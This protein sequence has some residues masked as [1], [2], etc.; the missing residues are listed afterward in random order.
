MSNYLNVVVVGLRDTGKST[1]CGGLLMATNGTAERNLMKLYKLASEMGRPSYTLAWLM[2]VRKLER[3]R[4]MTVDGNIRKLILPNGRCVNLMDAPGAKSFRRRAISM[5]QQADVVLVC[6]DDDDKF[7]PQEFKELLTTLFFFRIRTLAFCAKK[8]TSPLMIESVRRI[9]KTVGFPVNNIPLF[10]IGLVNNPAALG[11][12]LED[13][14]AREVLQFLMDAPTPVRDVKG[15]LLMLVNRAYKIGGVGTVVCGGIVRGRIRVGENVMI[16]PG[17]AVVP[18]TSLQVWHDNV[19]EAYAG[20][21]VGVVIKNYNVHEFQRGG[22]HGFLLGQSGNSVSPHPMQ[23]APVMPV[24]TLR[25]ND[26][27]MPPKCGNFT[28]PPY[29]NSIIV[30]VIVVRDVLGLRAK[31]LTSGASV[32]V[33]GRLS[34]Q[35]F[36]VEAVLARL[37]NAFETVEYRPETVER[38]S[39]YRLQLRSKEGL[40]VDTKEKNEP[41][42]RVILSD[43]V[44]VVAAGVVRSTAAV[45]VRRI[46]IDPKCVFA[47]PSWLSAIRKVFNVEVIPLVIADDGSLDATPN[48]SCVLC[49][50]HVPNFSK[51]LAVAS[52]ISILVSCAQPDSTSIYGLT[53][54]PVK[55][56]ASRHNSYCAVTDRKIN[57]D[58]AIKN[59]RRVWNRKFQVKKQW[60]VP[61]KYRPTP[62]HTALGRVIA[63]T[64]AE[65]REGDAEIMKAAL[66][67]VTTTTRTT[68]TSPAVAIT[69]SSRTEAT[70]LQTRKVVLPVDIVELIVDY[71]ATNVRAVLCVS[72]VS[73]AW[74][75]ATDRDAFFIPFLVAHNVPPPPPNAENEPTTADDGQL[76]L[77][78]R[79]YR[80]AIQA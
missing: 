78:T 14:S 72:R 13:S 77:R 31:P 64:R 42:S 56:A 40:V 30:D 46:A 55:L 28:L 70:S 45:A 22:W 43:S 29:T 6:V 61:L 25:A 68:P 63:A 66:T 49:G 79:P 35:H 5:A 48:V 53:V 51:F 76:Q 65:Q 16:A 18:I 27:V 37:D 1:L 7:C 52:N 32:L 57:E 11:L 41:F 75:V 69:T 10:R 2:D 4:C 38:K 60:F 47:D 20:S 24:R 74:A 19:T 26:Y 67:A 50:P 9:A 15:D 62:T 3:E 23:D 71:V 58:G 39:L 17:M 73:V 36:T 59:V 21:Q 33:A 44:G 80:T 34:S 54:K 8:A 12:T